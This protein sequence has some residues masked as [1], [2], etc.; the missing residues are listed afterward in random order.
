MTRRYDI[1][2][3]RIGATLLLFVFHVGMVFSPAPFYHIRN[4]ALS[5]AWLVVC[6]FIGL[7][8]MPLFFLLAGWSLCESMRARGVPGVVGERL[9]RLLVPLVFG[10]LVFMPVIKFLELSGGLD[11]SRNGLRVSPA[12]QDGFRAVIPDGLPVAAPFH[13]TFREFLP[14]FF[15]LDRF[16]WAHLWFV[17]YLLTFT[18]VY[19]PLFAWLLRRTTEPQRVPAILVYAPILPLALVQML[20]RP[21]WPGVQNLYDD[22]ANVAYY[23][24]Y[25][26]AGFLLARHPM[27]EIVAQRE[28]R[29]ALLLGI[30]TSGVL[31]GGLL[32]LYDAPSVMLAGSAVAGWCFVL[33]FLGLAKRFLDVGNAALHYLSEAAF[34]VYLLHQAAIVVPGY[35]LIQMPF[36]IATKSVLLLLVSVALTFAIYH[37]VVRTLPPLRFCLGMR[38]RVCPVPRLVT[39]AAVVALIV[40]AATAVYAET[41]EGRWYAEGGAAQIE[42]APCGEA[43]CGTVVWLRSPFDENGC[44][45]TDAQNPDATLRGREIVG[46]RVLTDLRPDGSGSGGWTGGLIYDPTSGRTYRCNLALDGPD[47]ARL[48]GYIGITLLGRTTTWLRVGSESRACGTRSS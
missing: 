16:T 44:P 40:A 3:L 45:L 22:W 38:P 26:F 9:R 30:A 17:A 46:L 7:W 8:H 10:C 25:L 36:G 27:V 13:E 12:L 33:A 6:G 18:V 24:T 43:L 21:Y 20:L 15:T 14:T 11:L 47:R 39:Q 28:W 35:W 32:R 23:S 29:R 41:P 37:C 2:W 34:P 1:D 42:I 4:D 19:L 48:R 5:F 31:L